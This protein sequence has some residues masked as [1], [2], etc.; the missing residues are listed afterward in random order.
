MD[1]LFK[2][3]ANPYLFLD[4]MISSSRMLE[5]VN[6]LVQI[7]ND[8][9]EHDTMWQF[10]LH[11]VFDKSYEDFLHES[12]KA[13]NKIEENIDFETTIKSSIEILQD[14]IPA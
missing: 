13:S 11:K 12:R 4:E 14:F 8:E 1:L 9:I 7:S 6:K 10:F 3:Y 2:R 5:F